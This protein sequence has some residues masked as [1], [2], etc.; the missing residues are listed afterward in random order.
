[1]RDPLPTHG[2]AEGGPQAPGAP[3]ESPRAGVWLAVLLLLILLG[4]AFGAWPGPFAE[5]PGPAL[6]GLGVAGLAW[7]VAVRRV[8]PGRSVGPFVGPFGGRRGALLLWGGAL[9]LRLVAGLGDARLSDDIHRYVWEG[10]LVAEGVSPY[11]HAPAEPEHALRRERWAAL[12]AGLNHPEVPAAYPPLSQAAFACL[13]QLAPDP[14]ED[15]GAG[16]VLV[17]R[18]G[19]L[20]ADLVVLFLLQRALARRGRG[21]LAALV[22]G[23]SP[24]VALEF[25]GSG[26]FDSLG[27]ALLLAA[28]LALERGARRSGAVLLAAGAMVKLLPAGLL[29]LWF[30]RGA[31]AARAR[32]GSVIA[33]ALT[34]ALLSSPLLVLEDGLR[35]PWRGLADYGLRWESFALLFPIVQGAWSTVAGALPAA[36]DGRLVVRAV[37]AVLWLAGIVLAWRRGAAAP[38]PMGFAAWVVG[39]FLVLTPTLHPWYLTWILPWLVF[40]PS[41]AWTLLVATAPLLYLPLVG[42]QARGEWVWPGWLWPSVAL[43]FLG[44]LAIELWPRVRS[45]RRDP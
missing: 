8:G 37:L 45:V 19:F 26:H 2:G 43:P 1:M 16:A 12:Y 44:L 35:T 22:W 10:R 13:V 6:L 38:S 9:A 21:P 24:L 5:R 34:I 3:P 15:G 30:A 31:S 14:A 29:P 4:C 23:W 20:A 17:L 33:F 39:S 28:L 36:W 11:A 42:W 40:V 32:L 18:A 41:M 27:I 25:A 7:V